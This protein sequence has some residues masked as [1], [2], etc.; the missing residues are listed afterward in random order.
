MAHNHPNKHEKSIRETEACQVERA[1]QLPVLVDFIHV[2]G[3]VPCVTIALSRE[4]L[5]E[6]KLKQLTAPLTLPMT[7]SSLSNIFSREFVDSKE[8][9]VVDRFV[10]FPPDEG[11]AMSLPPIACGFSQRTAV[12]CYFTTFD[13]LRIV[14]TSLFNHLH[15][16]VKE[17]GHMHPCKPNFVGSFFW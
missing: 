9:H 6:T 13:P 4:A 14:R 5:L 12:F 15:N 11:H 3:P 1:N 17:T 2:V 8:F 16:G 10:P 7:L